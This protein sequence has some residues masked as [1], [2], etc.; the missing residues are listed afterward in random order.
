MTSYHVSPAWW[1]GE[2]RSDNRPTLLDLV[3]NNTLDLTLASLLWLIVER[4]ASIVAAAGPQLAG[5]TTLI[6]AALDFMP[7]E[8]RQVLTRG[9]D[10]DFSFLD[11]TDPSVT[12]AL[13]PELSDH[14][15]AYL[16][17]DSVR[18][19]FDALDRGYSMMAT[20]HADTPQQVLDMLSGPPALVPGHLLHHVGFVANLSLSYGERDMT[21]RLGLLSTVT[22]SDGTARAV[23][24]IVTLARWF[25]QTDSFDLEES[26]AARKAIAENLKMSV[27]AIEPALRVKNRVLQ[28]LLDAAP[29]DPSELRRAVAGD[30]R[31]AQP[32][33]L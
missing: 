11:Q 32:R 7:T 8:Y 2:G 9:R 12:Y 6:T 5:K 18:T 3:R 25:P 20:I 22:R 15:P 26:D 1:G 13:V 23:P 24:D 16:W 17:G 31:S 21:R 28:T 19:L 33:S 29:M 4:K 14:T 10:E 30:Y 27:D